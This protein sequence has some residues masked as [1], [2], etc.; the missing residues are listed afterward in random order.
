MDLQPSGL[1]DLWSVDDVGWSPDMPDQIGWD[2]AAFAQ[3]FPLT[4]ES[5]LDGMANV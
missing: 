1:F 5:T 2:W 3:L 4:D